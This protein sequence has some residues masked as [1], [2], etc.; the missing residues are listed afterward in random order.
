MGF[1]DAIWLK[2]KIEEKI[3]EAIYTFIV[4]DDTNVIEALISGTITAGT[5]GTDFGTFQAAM[6]GTVRLKVTGHD[7]NS[8]IKLQLYLLTSEDG[9]VTETLLQSG[10][11]TASNTFY[12]DVAIKRGV[13]YKFRAKS[14]GSSN[15]VVTAADIRGHSVTVEETQII[16]GI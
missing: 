2:N 7:Y 5:S 16:Y 1:P 10:F 11:G 3:K 9:M 13:E 12:F 14:T 4:P 6:N 8:N 15:V